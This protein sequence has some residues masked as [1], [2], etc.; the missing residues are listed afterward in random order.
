MRQ[1]PRGPGSHLLDSRIAAVSL[2]VALLTLLAI[3]PAR[4]LRLIGSAPEN[5][6]SLEASPAEIRLWFS[7]PPELAI[8]RIGLS[9]H[10][11]EK[12]GEL[13]GGEEDTL[14]VEVLGN[15]E[16]GEHIVAWRTSS[17]DGHPIRGSILFSTPLAR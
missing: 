4:H 1:A 2:A 8:S 10:E 7:L 14:Y 13:Q 15:L 9:C 5:D 12:L 11:T 16:P 17:G 6:A 3:A